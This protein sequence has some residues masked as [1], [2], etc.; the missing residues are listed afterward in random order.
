MRFDLSDEVN[1]DIPPYVRGK[2]SLYH[3]KMCDVVINT[4]MQGG[5]KAEMCI[6]CG[7]SNATF[8][9]YVNTYPEFKE[10]YEFAELII[11]R[12]AEKLLQ[13]G[14]RGELPGEAFKY[15]SKLLDNKYKHLYE[16]AGNNTEITV[17]T[18]NLTPEQV[19]AKIAQKIGSLK[20]QGVDLGI[21]DQS[22][23]V[24]AEV[25]DE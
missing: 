4:A 8:D 25:I 20:A 5:F 12:E 15:L 24:D 2:L 23:I 3:P 9:K 13:K 18:I 11:L 14:A 19:S 10:S 21:T 6:N 1:R 17:N 16:K 7:I 22:N